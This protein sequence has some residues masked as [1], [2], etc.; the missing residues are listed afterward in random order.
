MCP[1]CLHHH[2]TKYPLA[3][4][5]S[6]EKPQG[7]SDPA[8]SPDQSCVPMETAIPELEKNFGMPNTPGKSP[9]NRISSQIFAALIYP[10][11]APELAGPVQAEP[12]HCSKHHTC[13]PGK[14]ALQE[15]SQNNYPAGLEE[16]DQNLAF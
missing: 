12:S 10:K 13:F 7:G 16:Q 11:H 14:N 15:I 3:G 9:W 8:G 1:K 6:L 5:S 4:N 2:P